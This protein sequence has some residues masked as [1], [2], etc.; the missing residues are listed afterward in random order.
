VKAAV[1]FTVPAENAALLS[2]AR[3]EVCVALI[4]PALIK[5]SAVELRQ[6]GPREPEETVFFDWLDKIKVGDGG[7]RLP[8][9]T[10]LSSA[11]PPQSHFIFGPYVKIPPGIYECVAHIETLG[12]DDERQTIDVEM[13]GADG[14]V[15]NAH[16]YHLP[17]E[18][19]RVGL[20]F[21]IPDADTSDQLVGP[22]EFRIKRVS[23]AQIKLTA[24]K[25]RR[26]TDMISFR[27]TPEAEPLPTV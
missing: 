2:D 4:A 25:V 5:I 8:D 16:S 23:P 15:L 20:P 12:K 1:R 11:E 27:E 7:H 10:I 14:A 17:A 26:L 18:R 21:A 24:L 3:F 19:C 9:G 22:I 6:A 13:V